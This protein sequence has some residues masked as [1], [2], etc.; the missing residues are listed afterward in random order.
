LPAVYAQRVFVA[1]GGLMSYGIDQP[2]MYR[3]AM[4]DALSTKH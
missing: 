2:D 3:H 4:V 1:A